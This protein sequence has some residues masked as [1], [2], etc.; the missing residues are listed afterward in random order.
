MVSHFGGVGRSVGKEIKKNL[1]DNFFPTFLK[2]RLGRLA[3]KERNL[4]PSQ[5]T[6]SI[7]NYNLQYTHEGYQQIHVLY[8]EPKCVVINA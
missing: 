3:K 2:F 8:Q 4:M 6:M 5:K 1:L 7:G